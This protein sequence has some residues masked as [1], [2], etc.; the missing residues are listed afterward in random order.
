MRLKVVFRDL[1]GEIDDLVEGLA[2][3]LGEARERRQLVDPQPVVQHEL[4]IVRIQD[5]R[6]VA[7]HD[8]RLTFPNSLAMGA[9]TRGRAAAHAAPMTTSDATKIQKPIGLFAYAPGSVDPSAAYM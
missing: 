5:V 1:A 4:E 8:Y 7:V 6:L 3:V 9:R 2:A